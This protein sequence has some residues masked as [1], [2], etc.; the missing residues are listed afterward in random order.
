VARRAIASLSAARQWAAGRR[1][2]WKAQHQLRQSFAA[3]VAPPPRV[4]ASY[5]ENSWIVP[6]A[7]VD[8]PEYIH[9]GD[10]VVV[11]EYGNLSAQRRPGGP[12]PVLRLGDGTR[13]QRF[14]NIVCFGS[15]TIGKDVLV[16]DRALISD[17]EFPIA[18]APADMVEP[19][20]IVIEDGAFLG[21]GC[22]IKPGV[23]IGKHAFVSASSVVTEDVGERTL[24][25]GVPARAVKRWS[26]DES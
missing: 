24:V 16:A 14:V 10:G 26:A 5:G 19:K 8:G 12:A 2:G 15:V 17:L 7:R 6:P 11:H 3:L 1:Q 25:A 18:G 4:F 9:V 23:T 13:I 20:P 22:V 21:A